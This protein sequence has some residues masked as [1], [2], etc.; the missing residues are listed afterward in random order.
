[1]K[2][3]LVVPGGVD[4]SGDQRVIPAMLSLIE[5]LSLVHEVHVFALRQDAM[6][7]QWT[8][9]GATIHNIGDGW[10]RLRAIHALRAEHRRAPFDRIQAIF[11]GSCS[12]V[13]V[14]AA[15]LLRERSLVPIASGELVSLPGIDYGGRRPRVG[16]LR[17]ALVLRTARA[18]PAADN[19]RAAVGGRGGHYGW[20]TVGG[21]RST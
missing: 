14:A 17:E 7:G 6:A 15:K 3:A 8:L 12:L 20:N 1:M 21:V 10:T 16:R 11:S 9:A 13:A 2:L 19:G 4:R 18:V 5:R